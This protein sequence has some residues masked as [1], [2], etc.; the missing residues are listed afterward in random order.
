MKRIFIAAAAALVLTQSAAAHVVLAEPHARAG[1]YYAGFFRISHGCGDEPTIAVR[2]DIPEGVTI[3]H[4]QPKPG[5]RLTIERAPLPAPLQ[6]EGGP[7]TERV[8]AI[9][10]RGRLPADEFDQF[11]VMLRLPDAAGPL[12]FPVTQTCAHS[13]RRWADIP[14]PNQAW[15]D[16]ANPAPVL[17]LEAPETMEMDH[18]H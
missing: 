16:V 1:S 8:A 13:E 6:S 12:Y 7:I 10:W 4:P 14:G 15:H 3:A 2:I 11:G 9:T 5:W 18:H 17:M